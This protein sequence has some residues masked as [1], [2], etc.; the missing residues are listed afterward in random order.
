MSLISIENLTF[1]YEGSARNVFENVNLKL[2]S[3]WKLGLFG[4]NGAG[5]STLFKLLCGAEEYRGK[6]SASVKFTPFPCAV[7][8]ESA[9][10]AELAEEMAEE[11]WKVYAAAEE[12]ALDLSAFSRPYNTLSEGEK[13]K[14]LLAA[15]FAGENSFL[16]IDEPTN[17][18][19]AEGRARA[20]A[21][22]K[23]QK[24]FMLIT[25]DRAFADACVDHVLSIERTK[26]VLQKGDM[27]SYLAERAAAEKAEREEN[28]RLKREISRLKESA[29]RAKTWADKTE[30]S[31]NE[32]VSGLRPDKGYIGHKAAKMMQ[33][34]KN[35]ESRRLAA[36]EEKEK[37]LKNT[38]AAEA[39]KMSAEKGRGGELLAFS[40]AEIFY[41]DFA[42]SK[43]VSF[44][45]RG[46]E[47]V[48]LSGA[49]GSGKSTVLRLAAGAPLRFTGGFSRRE[50]LKISY[51]EQSIES[52]RGEL[53]E[54]AASRGADFT[55]FLTLLRKMGFSRE[56]FGER[57][58]TMSAG[59]RK[60]VML[61]ASLA[62]G[63]EL[64]IWDEPLNYL[65]VFSRLQIEEMIKNS[66]AA[67]LAVE[68][69]AAFVKNTADKVVLF[70]EKRA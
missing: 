38:E 44:S 46:G 43:G 60:K 35:I 58:E 27:S 56:M 1:G 9:T 50:N 62:C 31:K 53:K 23:K 16:L 22:F 10:G 65:D 2:D 30:R 54:F 29:A 47:K 20:A 12:L 15:L 4:A 33:T 48:F 13:A 36:A 17:H 42:A 51:A 64:Y 66:P 69:D 57:A 7:K 14:F 5:K 63:A 8:N 3:N 45:V 52:V 25:H 55:L 28:E 41:G 21:F 39:L 40:G 68:H 34:A 67:L 59:Q 24:G 49:N 19:D 18:L 70:G 11:S 61:A 6:I 32:K 37:L 26:I